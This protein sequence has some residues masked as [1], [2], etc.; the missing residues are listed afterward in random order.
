VNQN[1][2]Q[3]V[4]LDRDGVINLAVIRDNKPY[5]PQSVKE[6]FV[7]PYNISALQTLHSAG[8]LLIGITNQPDVA[9]GKQLRSVV[10]EINLHLMSILPIEAF[11]VC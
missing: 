9:R 6:V 11:Y 10:E 7:P 4:F 1:S 3:A 2:R 5:P 8:F